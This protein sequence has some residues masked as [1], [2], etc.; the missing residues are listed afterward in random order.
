MSEIKVSFGALVGASTD[1]SATAGRIATK[2]EELRSSLAPMVATWEGQAAA[3]YQA[4]QAKWDT[5]AA[6]INAVL[7]NVSK[8]LA[9]AAQR[10]EQT[11]QVNQRRWA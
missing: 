9:D 10:Y 2:L 3:D 11:E 8:A 6:G 7:M 1:T 5:A 4:K